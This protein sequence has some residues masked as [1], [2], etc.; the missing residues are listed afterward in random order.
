MSLQKRPLYDSIDTAETIIVSGKGGVGKSTMSGALAYGQSAVHN[1]ETE[2]ID[3][4]SAHSSFDT[5]GLP[6]EDTDAAE[7][8]NEVKTVSDNLRIILLSA[9]VQDPKDIP[10]L[11]EQ[12]ETYVPDKGVLPV[13]RLAVHS[14]FFGIP[15]EHKSMSHVLQLMEILERRQHV[16]AD[17]RDGSR[18]VQMVDL[19]EPDITVIDSENTQGLMAVISSLQFL[20]HSLINVRDRMNGSPLNPSNLG[21]QATIG[22]QPNIKAYAESSVG[23]NPEPTIEIMRQFCE[24]MYDTRT[25]VVLVTNPG[26]NEVNQTVREAGHLLE[27]GM[28][29]DHVLMNRWPTDKRLVAGAKRWEHNLQE[30][31][32]QLPSQAEIGFSRVDVSDP[33]ENIDPEDS[34]VQEVCRRNLARIEETFSRS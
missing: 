34:A 2:L 30:R 24:R 17:Y 5:L 25:R 29:I 18:G 15:S 22:R 21:F 4:D 23:Q 20:E 14:R 8:C 13:L 26:R 1:Q 19:P 12:L 7:L 31:L 10:D 33:L 6:A 28:Q 32:G 3:L 9:L 27:R 16:V 11:N